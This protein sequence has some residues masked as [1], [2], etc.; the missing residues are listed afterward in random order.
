[1]GFISMEGGV[2]SITCGDDPLVVVNA[3]NITGGTINAVINP[4]LNTTD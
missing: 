2:V 1:M 4:S 3:L